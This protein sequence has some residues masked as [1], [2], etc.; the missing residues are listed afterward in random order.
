[1]LITR[2]LDYALR[3][4]RALRDGQLHTVGEITQ[5]QMLPQAFTYKIVKKLAAA[6]LIEIIRGNAGGCRLAADLSQTSLYDLMQ[7]ID[8]EVE[9]SACMNPD[10]SCPWREAH[11]GCAIHCRLFALQEK[12]DQELKNQSLLMLLGEL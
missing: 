2:E 9:L 3:V 10:Y 7:A 8:E 6:G 12:L 11:E 5:T 1:M 4:L